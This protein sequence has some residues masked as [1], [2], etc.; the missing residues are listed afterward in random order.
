MSAMAQWDVFANPSPRSRDEVPYLV[1]LQ[2]DLLDALPTRLVAPLARSAVED[3]G[4]PQ[5]LVPRFEIDGEP[6]LLRIQQAGP[7][8]RGVLRAP[9]ASL[10]AQ[11]H[12]IV[13]ALDAVISGL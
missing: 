1:V 13:D 4:L 6:L 2:S 3:P 10:R 5:R 11:S 12:R 8:D 9:V 7:V